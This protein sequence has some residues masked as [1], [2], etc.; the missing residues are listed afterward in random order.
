M[1]LLTR[2][3]L[4][5]KDELKIEKVTLDIETDEYVFV[6]QLVYF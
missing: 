3:G 2:E 6:R 5:K 1:A 4:L